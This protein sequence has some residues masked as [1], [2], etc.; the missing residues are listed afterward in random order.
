MNREEFISFIK[1]PGKLDKKSLPEINEL[2]EEFPYFQTGHLLFL[3]N[4]H[5]LDHIRFGSQLKSSA[6]FVANREVL[7]RLLN[8]SAPAKSLEKTDSKDEEVQEIAVELSQNER[9]N[10]EKGETGKNKELLQVPDNVGKEDSR[11][12]DI[13]RGEEVPQEEEDAIRSKEDLAD[14]I[15]KRLEEIKESKD[16]PPSVNIVYDTEEQDIKKLIDTEKSE[17]DNNEVEIFQLDDESGIGSEGEENKEVILDLPDFSDKMEIS[18]DLLELENTEKEDSIHSQDEDLP[19]ENLPGKEKKNLIPDFS[20]TAKQ[21]E[22]H[23]FASWF[24][25]LNNEKPDEGEA[26]SG[27]KNA[28]K[29]NQWQIIDRF[30]E[31]NPRILPSKQVPE[32]NTDISIDSTRDTESMLTETLAKIYVKQGYYSK[33]IFIYKKLSLKFPEKSIYFAGQ[34]KRIE[35]NIN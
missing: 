31:D 9:D 25:I 1:D 2:V 3:K 14:E 19:G 15:K 12:D 33:A 32:E 20:S 16:D 23:S 13:P 30:I 34:I 26:S 24:S 27:I 18:G 10:K 29:E 21:K 28:K 17:E 35:K 8:E 11:I 7:Y 6:I 22:V 5:L 4:L